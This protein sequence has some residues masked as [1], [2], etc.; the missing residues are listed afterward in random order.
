VTT[1]VRRDQPVAMMPSPANSNANARRWRSRQ[2]R[3]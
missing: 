3:S 1:L 2:W